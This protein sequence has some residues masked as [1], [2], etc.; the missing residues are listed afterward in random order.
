MHDQQIGP[1]RNREPGCSETGIHGSGDFS[2]SPRILHLQS[3]D[4]LFVIVNLPY[5]KGLIAILHYG[6]KRG[7]CIWHDPM[8]TNRGQFASEEARGETWIK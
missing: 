3:V 2:D 5:A 7:A 6:E 4:R 1:G 8:K